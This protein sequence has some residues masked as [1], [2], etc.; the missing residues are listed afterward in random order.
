MHAP[1]PEPLCET[2]PLVVDAAA[3]MRSWSIEKDGC[4]RVCGHRH[5]TVVYARVPFPHHWHPTGEQ[6]TRQARPA[7][8][9]YRPLP[10]RPFPLSTVL[11]LVWLRADCSQVG[12]CTSSVGGPVL[13]GGGAGGIC[14]GGQ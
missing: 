6:T 2:A 1:S 7:K 3:L 11:P 9:G 5:E 12:A 13:G 8:D 10:P 4:K 14:S